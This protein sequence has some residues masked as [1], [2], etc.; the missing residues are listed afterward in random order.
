MQPVFAHLR[1]STRQLSFEHVILASP[2]LIRIRP[3][4]PDLVR[5][6]CKSK[7][8]YG[9]EMA[10]LTHAALFSSRHFPDDVISL[11]VRWYLR[12]S[13]SYRDLEEI[14]RER[15][16]ADRGLGYSL[17]TAAS[18]RSDRRALADQEC[19]R[20]LYLAPSVLAHRWFSIVM[21]MPL[22]RISHAAPSPCYL[23]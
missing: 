3:Q 16:V 5:P 10:R 23:S 1:F 8:T 13:L 18:S 6:C 14:L 9:E 22:G 17:T 21:A 4:N 15:G 7:W 2:S 19:R 11:A 12:Y 20:K